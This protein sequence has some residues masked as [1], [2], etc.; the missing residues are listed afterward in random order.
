MRNFQTK[1]WKRFQEFK[2]APAIYTVE[3]GS[4]KTLDYWAWT[5]RLQNLAMGLMDAGFAAGTRMGFVTP[6]GRDWIDLAMA[7]WL[8]GGCLVP[9]VPGRDREETLR[10]LGRSGCDW[11]VVVD[12]NER[13][14]LRGPGGSL[15]SHLKWVFVDGEP[16]GDNT[17]D[18]EA[19]EETGRDLIRR[20]H[21]KKL[22]K[23]IYQLDRDA[24]T[25]ILF[26]PEPGED[27]QGA[28]FS[29]VKVDRQLEGIARQMGLSDAEPAMVASMM[30]F[31][32]FSSFL[33]TIATLYRGH[34]I[35]L[36]PTLSELCDE[37][38]TLQ[39]TH[40]VCGP[41]YLEQLG[42]EWE[43]KLDDAP[44]LLKR[45]AGSNDA[46]TSTLSRALGSIGERAARRFLYDPIRRQFGG[47]LE[48]IHVFGGRC[49]VG[50][51][52]IL[53]NADIALL[54]HFGVPEAGL[55][56]V[57]HPEARRPD[58]AGRPIEGVAT[59]IDGA[60]TGAVGELCLRGDTLF[61]DYWTGQGPRHVDDEG[62]LHT[63]QSARLKSGFL[64]LEDSDESP[65]SRD[66]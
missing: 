5:R 35:C 18:I 6:N 23:R 16:A 33:I 54:G 43:Q 49:P 46:D 3:E 48:V 39:P 52:P 2:E 1:L 21:A 31:G 41:A 15:P 30:S 11:I 62:W 63:G 37:F 55:S 28:F 42:N 26:D 65:R 38:E 14:R 8:V 12:N 17:F 22:A 59:K 45:L 64:F 7:T 51:H 47:K 32:W 36:T 25:L 58:S 27:A 4:R 53:D 61:D 20:G 66:I 10:C 60:R 40:L 24:P 57:E 34:S 19:L 13:G 56:H 50:L 29:G 44:D 9:L